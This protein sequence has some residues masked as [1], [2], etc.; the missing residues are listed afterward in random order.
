MMWI[1][2]CLRGRGLGVVAE[3]LCETSNPEIID[4]VESAITIS[5][6]GKNIVALTQP[7]SNILTTRATCNS[8]IYIR[9]YSA[10]QFSFEWWSNG[11]VVY[12]TPAVISNNPIQ[13]PFS[14]DLN[15]GLSPGQTFSANRTSGL[16]PGQTINYRVK[17]TAS[18]NSVINGSVKSFTIPF[19][20]TIY[21][22]APNPTLPENW[23]TGQEER[24]IIQW[25]SVTN[26]TSYRIVVARNAGDLPTDPSVA[27]C[28]ACI[29]N[30]PTED[31]TIRPSGGALVAGQT[32][33]WKVKA[34]SLDRFGQWSTTRQF[35]TAT[36]SLL[37]MPAISFPTNNSYGVG[38][39]PNIVWSNVVGA[40]SYRLMIAPTAS[41]L[42]TDPTDP[43]CPNCTI[44]T[45]V[46]DASFTIPPY[47]LSTPNTYV[48]Q[49]KARNA[50]QYG[51]WSDKITFNTQLLNPPANYSL[52]IANSV[53]GVIASTPA[54]INCGVSCN[55]TYP[56]GYTVALT[57]TPN[58]GYTFT[59][60]SG[61]CE[62]YSTS[63][64]QLTMNAT[65]SVAANYVSN[66]WLSVTN[67]N[68]IG[69]KI[70]S[71][72]GGIDCG[73]TC[74]LSFPPNTSLTLTPIANPGYSFGG[75]IGACT[76]YTGN[77]CSLQLSGNRSI[78][79]IFNANKQL[80]ITVT[81]EVQGAI[82]SSPAG[83]DC[84]MTCS[85]AFPP[86]SD[87]ILTAA[88]TSSHSMHD[89]GGDCY[90]ATGDT[91]ELTLSEARNVTANYVQ[92][93]LL[94]ITNYNK[95][96]GT[97]TSDSGGINC[98]DACS[99][100]YA[101]AHMV[102]LTAT[103][104]TGYKFVGWIG[105]CQGLELTCARP[106]VAA[107]NVY[108]NFEPIFAST[109]PLNV[110]NTNKTGGTVSSDTGGLNCG[111][112]C[113]HDYLAGT[114]VAL[115]ATSASGFRFAGWGGA[116][117]G[118]SG[119]SCTLTMDATKNVTANFLALQAQTYTITDLGTL[120]DL[121]SSYSYAM[122]INASGEIAGY[123]LWT[124]PTGSSDSHAFL[125]DSSG[126][127][128]LGTLG[129][130]SWSSMAYGIN[131]VGQIVGNA[132]T[133]GDVTTHAFLYD[134]T[135]MHDLGTLVDSASNTAGI[136][137]YARGISASGKIVG[138]SSFSGGTAS[139]YHAY[140]FDG[141][142][143]H[144]IQTL[145]GSRS[146]AS[147]INSNGQ[148][149][150]YSDITGDTTYHAFVYD[151][152][153]GIRDLQTLGGTSS[154]ARSINVL[155]QIV[156]NSS[157]TM[158]V[159]DH[160]F[161]YDNGHMRDLGTLGGTFSN[162]VSI[163][164]SGQ[165]VGYSSLTGE[166]VQH[167][168]LFD[169]AG[170]HDL[171]ALL[172]GNTGGWTLVEANAI[173]ENG[174]IIANGN[175]TRANH[176]FLLTPIASFPITV[177]LN[178]QG[179][180]T[181]NPAGINCGDVCSATFSANQLVTFTVG[182]SDGN[183]FTGWGGD[184]SGTTG[185]TCQVTIN[186]AKNISA[187]FVPNY[188]LTVTNANPF[189]GTVTSDTGGIDCGA[190]CSH[191][192]SSG[193][194]TILSA[195]PT[196]GFSFAG[197]GGDCTGNSGNTCQLSLNAA[198]TVTAAFSANFVLTI[199]NINKSGGTVS[200]S[201]GDISCGQTCSAVYFYSNNV[202]LSAIPTTGYRFTGWSEG[203]E[204]IVSGNCNVTVNAKKDITSNFVPYYRLTVANA[205]KTGGTVTSNV[206]GINCGDTCS[207]D[208]D[209][210]TFVTLT[211]T[212]ASGSIFVRWSGACTGTATCTVSMT[213]N[214]TVTA[215]YMTPSTFTATA[216]AGL[217]GSVSPASRSVTSGASAQ[218]TA[219]ANTGYVTNGAVGG[220]CPAGSWNGSNYTTGA[221]PTNCTASF[222]FTRGIPQDMIP[223]LPSRGGWR[224]IFH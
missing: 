129:F 42:T 216:S 43:N 39:T 207:Q 171:N 194:R 107:T 65:K 120:S 37:P 116:C 220:T 102:T 174:Q 78:T 125:Y 40:S 70:V 71:D 211:S 177:T 45:T 164:N 202:I 168:A 76:G 115:S 18:D 50:S 46:T 111:A 146:Y 72:I 162:A 68:P 178:G 183:S 195:T 100:R 169:S 84:G 58:S 106:I 172:V 63:I 66:S 143:M 190:T 158:N 92:N 34:R 97:I 3:H 218:F 103:P 221:I 48:V 51:Q 86:N 126:M 83:I 222:Y 181:S 185:S 5:P 198:R 217:G 191:N 31:T 182:Q 32:Y 52:T 6:L 152:V 215:I 124:S 20:D 29:I 188:L 57:A 16:S 208:Y 192:Y 149:V 212:P 132:I 91:C 64:C 180:I 13:Q 112:M 110:A 200:S 159:A 33:Y 119:P 156:G 186:S 104:A 141:T 55:A 94:S 137:S 166:S 105:D 75:W 41:Q 117:Y 81:P 122:D 140:L 163:N 203:C 161:I 60:W 67:S 199:S 99:A 133:P 167:A 144:D 28:A 36:A 2:P 79:G 9:N 53:Q 17:V 73:G 108:A 61:D 204:S 113:S 85:A 114:A 179:S 123:S 196:A 176:A 205:N 145:G 30:Q 21:L 175:N 118:A 54:G 74:N 127:H 138:F 77:T 25:S 189:G 26:A 80:T 173:N 224:A 49:V 93:F 95:A 1:D 130:R 62:S 150:G 213:A 88:S 87:V 8:S 223:A 131:D 160:A 151:K 128:D 214:T 134:S 19:S 109:Y 15:F 56:S 22:P 153:G 4:A 90:Y 10:V 24:P 47:I 14:A 155:G 136:Y 121:D 96:D 139:Q 12:S 44:N 38:I 154:I 101:S 210:G 219:T 89:W 209:S 135:G 7:C 27:D 157:L 170:I 11:G 59:G 148:V 82:T 184:C 201:S 197:W 193:S 142:G 98:G 23:A 187:N 165:I 35:K 147:R 69:G 206:G